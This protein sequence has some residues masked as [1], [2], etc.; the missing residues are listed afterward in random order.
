M[1]LI[2][3]RKKLG[4]SEVI[5]TFAPTAGFKCEADSNGNTGKEWIRDSVKNGIIDNITTAQ[6]VFVACRDLMPKPKPATNE[7]TKPRGKVD[8]RFH[9][10][11]VDVEDATEAE[12]SATAIER[13][14]TGII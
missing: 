12:K 1:G 11:Y 6:K 13:L 9:C 7:W 14:Q 3:Q 2:K 5:H 4:L 8:G 10:L